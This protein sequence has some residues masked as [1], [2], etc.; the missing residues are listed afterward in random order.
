MTQVLKN[1]NAIPNHPCNSDS[2]TG[3]PHQC[4]SHSFQVIKVEPLHLQGQE[5]APGAEKVCA[6]GTILLITWHLNSVFSVNKKVPQCW[7]EF[8]LIGEVRL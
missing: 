1:A 4:L 7:M 2:V 8:I 6:K 5:L 3:R